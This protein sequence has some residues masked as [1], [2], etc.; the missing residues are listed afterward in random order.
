MDG[1]WVVDW[2]ELA[3]LRERWARTGPSGRWLPAR[4][5]AKVHENF[6]AFVA[7]VAVHVSGKVPPE[8]AMAMVFFGPPGIPPPEMWHSYQS[9]HER[10]T[11]AAKP[12]ELNPL[13]LMLAF[14]CGWRRAVVAE[15]GP[16]WGRWEVA[17]AT[18]INQV[19]ASLRATNHLLAEQFPQ[20]Q[21]SRDDVLEFAGDFTVSLLGSCDCGHH[22][23]GCRKECGRD[24][25]FAP[26]DVAEWN[27]GK[28]HLRPFIDQ[29]VR[30]TA[31]RQIL[32]AAFAESL[33]FRTMEREG[34]I[35]R[36]RVEFKS[37]PLCEQLYEEETCP[38]PG[39][40]GPGRSP[41]RRVARPNWLIHAEHEGGNYRE[42]I[43]WVC[44][45]CKNI[46]PIRFKLHERVVDDPC[47]M[48]SWKPAPEERAAT[49]TVWV[50]LPLGERARGNWA[51]RDDPY[52]PEGEEGMTDDE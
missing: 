25:C 16:W 12:R 3:A 32:G 47:P 48:C 2:Q 5:A 43:R 24:C 29:A 7:F 37:C 17:Y 11:V 49:I 28:C 14:G 51:G 50:R 26:H 39:C 41:V 9:L 23:R 34:R 6:A 35:S 36:R 13:D 18:M 40:D 21:L 46:Y 1:E 22:R 30:G 15:E 44:G 4:I 19:G 31:T 20:F 27:P 42:M 33:T 10:V 8:P 45:G 38:T 52:D